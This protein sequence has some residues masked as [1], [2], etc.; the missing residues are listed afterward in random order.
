MHFESFARN[1]ALT[2]LMTVA[3]APAA[4][5]RGAEAP[6]SGAA[7]PVATGQPSR[8]LVA[9]IR[10]EPVSLASRLGLSGG[11]TLTT[12]R[13][14][15]NAYLVI[16]DQRGE[17]QPYLAA[18]SP[19]VNSESWRV[20]DDGRME[21]TYRL[22][23][24][25]VWHDSTPITADDFVFGWRV[26]ASPEL[27]TANS[28]PTSLIDEVVAA[29]PST[30]TIR[31]KRPYAQAG[32][33]TQEF[34]PLPRHV[35]GTAFESGV[36]DTFAG[37]SYWTREFVGAGPFR[38]ERWE[39]GAY[40]E[41]V[42]F[43]RHVLGAPKISRLRLIFISDQ[44]AALASLLAGDVHFVPEDGA[45]RFQQ[46]LTLQREWGPRNGGNVLIK[47][48]LFRATWVQFRPE[49]LT[50]PGLLDVRVRKALALTIDKQGINEGLFE[51]QG[52][53]SDVPFIPNTVGYHAAIEPLVT[54][55]PFD[56]GRAQMLLTDA[57]YARGADGLWASPTAGRLAFGLLTGAGSQNES[58]LSIL[59]A[60]WRQVGFEV[61]E[62]VMPAAQAQ[63][64]QAR[65][66]F[67][68]LST[69]SFPL[70]EDTLALA[71]TAGT[72][73]PENRWTGR[74]RGSWSNLEFDRVSDTFT[75]TLDQQQRVQLIGQLV[76]IFTD[77]LP[78]LPL[79]FS[80][81]PI[82]HVAALRGPQN[83]DPASDIA[84]NVHE[85][86]FR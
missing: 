71:S 39:P 38:V 19:R 77:E 54:R 26:Y 21:T 6:A 5:P 2:V 45:I 17:P 34:P 41:S 11:A 47:P 59:G 62:S 63:D 18:E 67:P 44:N 23:P 78:G 12:T 9:A 22:K 55:Y 69:I 1:L 27:G 35:L 13:R 30:V 82:A 49:V 58:E 75:T 60:G 73:R 33:L 53:M 70:G 86:E 57:G 36:P 14:L 7:A 10:V 43:D 20:F 16:F 84:W 3:C 52:I 31:W 66:S 51:G 80:P 15:F 83:V 81:T 40:I 65:S 50:T 74:N 28:P 85:W 32:V 68:G 24:N 37:H 29:G 56:P 76:R 25:L 61:N 46:A 64:G 72:P 79:Y 48:D 8:T 4:A 42:A